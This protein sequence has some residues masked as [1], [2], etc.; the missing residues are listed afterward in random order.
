MSQHTHLEDRRQPGPCPPLTMCPEGRTQVVGRGGQHL[1]AE[2]MCW[3]GFYLFLLLFLK[4]AL[5]GLKLRDLPDSTSRVKGLMAPI[6]TLYLL[7]TY[8]LTLFI[9]R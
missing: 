2:P 6:T 4:V 5:A 1:P 7:S 3:P 8:L 9:L